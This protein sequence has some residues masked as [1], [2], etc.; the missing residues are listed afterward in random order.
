MIQVTDVVKRYGNRDILRGV[1]LQVSAGEVAALI[2]RSGCG[3]S[4]LLRIINGL[5]SHDG[6]E[7]RVGDILLPASPGRERE[8][9]L[10]QIRQ[11]VGMVFQKC[12][13]FPH[14]TVLENITEAPVHVLGRPQA[15]A[16]LAA[17]QLL[18]R[19]GLADKA[20]ASPESL[21]GGEQQRVAIA[22]TLAM[23]P[24]LILL[25]EPTSALDPRSSAE[26][27]ALLQDLARQGQGMIVVSHTPSFVRAIAGTVYVLQDGRIVEGGPAEQVLNHPQHEAT[28]EFLQDAGAPADSV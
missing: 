27:A 21:S 20:D 16:T 13:L 8:R 10:L 14:R 1:S 19:V 18:K 17:R 28:R 4:S 22:R 23:E 5:E 24:A 25:D 26:V 6:G 9:A 11:R 7:I 15:D 12:H 3:K 2:G